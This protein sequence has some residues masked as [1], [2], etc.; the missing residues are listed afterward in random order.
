MAQSKAN[1]NTSANR[2][3]ALSTTPKTAAKMTTRFSK[4]STPATA[5]Q[6]SAKEATTPSSTGLRPNGTITPHDNKDNPIL[7]DDDTGK[8]I[9][10]SPAEEKESDDYEMVKEETNSTDDDVKEDVESLPKNVSITNTAASDNSSS[11]VDLNDFNN[12]DEE[13]VE[14]LQCIAAA[15]KKN[16]EAKKPSS[17][18][19]NESTDATLITASYDGY[20]DTIGYTCHLLAQCFFDKK[21]VEVQKPTPAIVED[22]MELTCK[23]F[24]K[25][26]T[27]HEAITVTPE[28]IKIRGDTGSKQ[29]DQRKQQSK[30][31]R[32]A[33]TLKFK[34]APIDCPIRIRRTHEMIQDTLDNNLVHKCDSTFP[35][36]NE[37]K[38]RKSPCHCKNPI[39]AGI[40]VGATPKMFG[41][42]EI[43]YVEILWFMYMAL[44]PHYSPGTCPVNFGHFC[45]CVGLLCRHWEGFNVFYVYTKSE[46]EKKYL[47]AANKTDD[48]TN[49]IPHMGLN[50]V[51][52][53]FVISGKNQEKIKKHILEK[54]IRPQH[55]WKIFKVS[56]ISPLLTREQQ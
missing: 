1:N 2:F 27:V 37:I 8:M 5:S 40:L 29:D 56:G 15:R 24:C 43:D 48:K 50:L 39:A 3:S 35:W 14:S 18:W 54:I 44:S 46:L 19:D 49:K 17:A 13:Y 21:A 41:A 53:P 45:R 9:V 36:A 47:D 22:I 42:S 4:T 25:N 20:D 33:I 32:F 23:L 26:V 12:E 34:K 51:Y 10:E 55:S 6:L 7:S 52:I 16:A 30:E 11:H 38:I 28:K 31:M